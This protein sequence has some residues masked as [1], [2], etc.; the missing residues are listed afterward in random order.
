[1]DS[2]EDF[3]P[4]VHSFGNYTNQSGT[5]L[6][7]FR[8]ADHEPLLPKDVKAK[9]IKLYPD[10][11]FESFIDKIFVVI[12][13]YGYGACYVFDSLSELAV[14]W[15]SDRMVANFF[16]L[17]CPYLFD[18]KTVT[19]FVLFRDRHSEYTI[20]KIHKTAQVIL[21]VYNKE[22]KHYILP[23]KV[24]KRHSPTMY[25]LHCMS[26]NSCSPILLSA[27]ISEIL[28]GYEQPWIDSSTKLQNIRAR[29]FYQAYRMLQDFKLGLSKFN[30]LEPIK[31][32]II[33]MAITRD[34]MLFSNVKKFFKLKDLLEI[35]R[36]MIGSGLIGGKSVGMLLAQAILKSSDKKWIEKLEQHDS[37]FIGSDVY[38]TYLVI[39]KCW[40][41]RYKIKKSENF[42]ELA[43]EARDI[44]RNG[45][46][47]RDI[48]EQFQNI[49]NYFGQS[50]IIVRSSSLLE[51][52]YGNAFSGKYES[53]YLANQGTPEERLEAFLDAVR[54]VYESTLSEDALMY[55]QRRGIL[56][57]DE[58]MAVLVQR[59]SGA[60]YGD[61]FYPQL[62]GVGYSFNPFI[63]NKN[64]DP[65]AGLIRLVFGLGTRAVE[66]HDDDYTRIIALNMPERRPETDNDEK[67]KYNQRK[68]DVL[69]LKENSFVSKYFDEIALSSPKLPIDIFATRDFEAEQRLR[70]RGREKTIYS[71]DLDKVIMRSSIVKDMKEIMDIL[72]KVYNYPVDIE[73]TI[74]FTDH[75]N[76][77]IY[78]LQ[79]R[80]LQ[81]R[82]GIEKFEEPPS[83]IKDEDV[84][85]ITQGPIIGNGIAK[86]VSKLIYV[87]PEEYS[88]LAMQERYAVARL[89]GKLNQMYKS[90]DED[91]IFLAGPGR[92]ATT[93]PSLGVPVS[94]HEINTVSAICEIAEMHDNLC[95][96]VSLGTHFFN[97][98]VEN[99]MLYIAIN[100]KDADSLFN[101]DILNK[102]ENKLVELIPEARK[103]ENIIKIIEESDEIRIK[104]YAD[105]VKQKAIL[106]L[107]KG[108]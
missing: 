69:N 97:D 17:T 55:R 59:V 24:W 66:R 91:I 83:D 41:I 95:P 42:L 33:R 74:N 57:Q 94:F 84:I 21:D 63:W 68:V 102:F 12:E 52:A 19:Y 70:E 107:E 47:P 103:Y 23:L 46:F 108:G 14:D 28:T 37:F 8:F 53:V 105:P 56:E 16:M 51:D 67:K 75:N 77:K 7:Y 101:R 80:P 34:P 3:L 2:L 36:R 30:D 72:E 50:P 32:K 20:S 18:Y 39:N 22:N 13:K 85:L 40:W 64:I 60:P 25:M 45:T 11:G 86:T 89:I 35:G 49:L 87:A 88:K 82:S 62:A 31:E 76:Y 78:I 96:D 99:D 71:L 38:Y 43:S 4:Y 54:K 48:L 90:S 73:L 9:V 98:L 92:W 61:L 29:T 104:L 81:I 6:I 27:E 1:M 65:E 106:Y 26:E 58:Q 15:Y 100:P 5:P 44:L 10:E 79:C 93:S